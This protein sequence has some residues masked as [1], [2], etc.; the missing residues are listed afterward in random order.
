MSQWQRRTSQRTAL[1]FE[2]SNTR[3]SHVNEMNT[4]DS[5]KLKLLN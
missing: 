5:E 2:V 1:K 3:Y 4:T